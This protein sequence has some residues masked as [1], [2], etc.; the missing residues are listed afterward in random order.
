MR[1][2]LML[3][4]V[5]G[6]GC[7]ARNAG[8]ELAVGHPRATAATHERIFYD[9][10]IRRSQSRRRVPLAGVVVELLDA[11]HGV[12]AA[13]T[14]DA[15]GHFAVLTPR[16]AAWLWVVPEMEEPSIAV[17]E[18]ELWGALLPLAAPQRGLGVIREVVEG[19]PAKVF[20]RLEAARS[21]LTYAQRLLG[22]RGPATVTIRF[23][24]EVP[25]G[26]TASARMRNG[27]VCA[28]ITMRGDDAFNRHVLLHEIGHVVNEI[29]GVDGGHYWWYESHS[30]THP[31]AAWE[32]G[33]ATFFAGLMAG[34]RYG[35]FSL[36]GPMRHAPDVANE[37]AVARVLWDLVDGRA[38][39]PDR[40][41]D[42]MGITPDR[43]WS[44]MREHGGSQDLTLATFLTHLVERGDISAQDLRVYLES[45]PPTPRR[46]ASTEAVL[47]PSSFSGM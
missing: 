28:M 34:G 31:S 29:I 33:R 2:A 1:W 39:I 44:A 47:H 21:A 18:P 46:L 35:R 16:P 37:W 22:D 4:F 41:T 42:P 20:A 23:Q 24:P 9:G 45:L 36:E 3:L 5:L 13:A 11:E 38:G 15:R 27:R 32:E 10:V 14:T 30:Q 40:D 8:S 25:G 17:E 12:L 7:G 19:T 6:A 26:S 43:L